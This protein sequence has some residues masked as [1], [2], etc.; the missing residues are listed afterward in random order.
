M[1]D[2]FSLLIISTA[3]LISSESMVESVGGGSDF[4]TGWDQSDPTHSSYGLEW[5]AGFQ[6]PSLQDLALVT[7]PSITVKKKKTTELCEKVCSDF[8]NKV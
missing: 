1:V 4:K 6:L 8:K 7:Y 2:V 3:H 5:C